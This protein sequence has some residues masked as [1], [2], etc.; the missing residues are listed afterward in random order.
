MAWYRAVGRATD[1]ASCTQFE[2]YPRFS[3]KVHTI[4]SNVPT[5]TLFLFTQTTFMLFSFGTSHDA[6]VYAWVWDCVSRLLYTFKQKQK[7]NITAMC[8]NSY[9]RFEYTLRHNC[10]PPPKWAF[11]LYL[12]FALISIYV[13]HTALTYTK[14][15]NRFRLIFQPTK[16][17]LKHT[18]A[19]IESKSKRKCVSTNH[20]N[21]V[22]ESVAIP[23]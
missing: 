8:F 3:T 4:F 6:T 16:I 9:C 7:H 10:P 1:S 18:W 21:R 22:C 17:Q 23:S 14:I 11:W 20:F 12:A 19:T 2:C 13:Y 5:L 15:C